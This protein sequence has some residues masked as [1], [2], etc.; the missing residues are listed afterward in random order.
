MKKKI[1]RLLKSKIFWINVGAAIILIVIVFI[2]I[3]YYLKSYTNF[4]ETIAV[5]NVI[6]LQLDEVENAIAARNLNFVVS[7]SV[8]HDYFDKGAVVEQYPAPGVK[9]KEGRKIYLITNCF[10]DE[11]I[12]MPEFVGYT[13]RQVHS[14]AETYGLV[15]GHLRYV[16]DIA[17]NV[18]IRQL[19]NDERIDAGELVPKGATIDLLVGLGLSDRKTIVP[20]LTGLTYREA[21]DKLLQEYLNVGAV[22]YDTTVNTKNDS[23]KSMVFRQSPERDTIN[24]VNLGYNI[25][26]WLTTDTTL[27]NNKLLIDEDI[28]QTE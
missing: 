20:D 24:P 28:E 3:T 12:A 10:E 22:V 19:Y 4:G 8:H 26:I 6:G 11:M 13:I 9:V 5:P 16:P 21:S 27:I 14:F 17:V 15:I 2:G 1:L 23:V 25:D 18:V 7:D